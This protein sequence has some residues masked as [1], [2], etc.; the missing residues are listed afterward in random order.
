MNR[1]HKLLQFLLAGILSIS[2]VTTIGSTPLTLLLAP[3]TPPVSE[4]G[5][6]VSPP[7]HVQ[8]DLPTQCNV[9]WNG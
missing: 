1:K 3:W 6:V 2:F 8:P 4:P 9:N 5:E 7:S